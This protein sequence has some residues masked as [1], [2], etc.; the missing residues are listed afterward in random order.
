VGEG[1]GEEDGEEEGRQGNETTY[2][3]NTSQVV[4]HSSKVNLTATTFLYARFRTRSVPERF[5]VSV[6]NSRLSKC[7]FR[8]P[9]ERE[10]TGLE[11]VASISNFVFPPPPPPANGDGED[12]EPTSIRGKGYALL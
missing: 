7:T 3:A 6:E 2:L 4:S 11:S 10:G 9:K 8:N 1:E 12:R 5:I